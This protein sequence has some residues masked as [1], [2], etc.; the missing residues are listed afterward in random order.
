MS[1]YSNWNDVI[2]KIRGELS[3]LA[4]FI[5]KTRTG[6]DNLENTVRIG[7]E[8]FPEASSQLSAVTGDLENAAN[9]IMEILEGLM[10]EQDE[11]TAKINALAGWIAKTQ[12]PEEGQR[13]LKEIES[14]NAKS[15]SDTMDIFAH[16]SFQD[17]T[18]Q[19]LKK[20]IS[21][22]AVVEKKLLEMALTFGIEESGNGAAPSERPTEQVAPIDQ[23]IVDRLMKELRANS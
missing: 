14:M 18:G 15:R 2:N 16:M 1:E 12:A 10:T 7:S 4:S 21:S 3:S 22:L 17:L 11:T 13:L 19:K 9:K 8:R 23:D 6:I 20:V 5:D